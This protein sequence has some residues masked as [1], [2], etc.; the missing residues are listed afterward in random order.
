VLWALAATLL[1][2]CN[3]AYL[4]GFVYPSSG[5]RLYVGPG[6][7]T[8]IA[9]LEGGIC[10]VVE[11]D[12]AKADVENGALAELY[13]SLLLAAPEEV[14]GDE[15]SLMEDVSAYVSRLL[16]EENYRYRRLL[17]EMLH[18]HAYA[19][20]IGPLVSRMSRLARFYTWLRP[21]YRRSVASK[22]L[23]YVAEA[24]GLRERWIHLSEA[25]I[26]KPQHG[27]V[28][29]AAKTAVEVAFEATSPSLLRAIPAEAVV[30]GVTSPLP[31]P[32]RDPLLY[33]RLDA[34]RL[35]TKLVSFEKQLYTLTG[36][37]KALRARR[38]GVIRSAKLVETRD[39]FI[40]A[41]VKHYRD[42]TVAK[43]LLAALLSLPLPQPRLSPKTRLGAEY[44]YNRV[45]EEKGYNVAKPILV[46]PRRLRAA[47]RYIPGR[48]LAELLSENNV[49]KA[50]YSYGE[51]LARIHRDGVALWDTNPSNVIQAGDGGLY[52]VDLEQAREAET[53]AEKA[54]D[55]AVAVYY[56]IPYALGGAAERARLMAQGYID[57]GGDPAVIAE[58]ARYRYAAPFAAVVPLTV[59]ERV[60]RALSATV[61]SRGN[62]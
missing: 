39:G 52:L 22:W 36:V 28:L 3:A 6:E 56:S 35:A 49:H 42:V 61:T 43:W 34:A 47:Y 58:S 62:T 38:K 29:T 50:Y 45:L 16:G 32:L 26:R 60:R 37:E 21:L 23:H 48:T 30:E 11:R 25:P 40:P 33:L 31:P 7:E 13:A 19:A 18:R 59:L 5:L 46:D 41:V 2:N 10:A 1:E 15:N 27:I 54:W 14:I 24:A 53:L 9:R 44:H 20:R 51:L 12:A 17:G 8:R 57:A 55:I 4:L